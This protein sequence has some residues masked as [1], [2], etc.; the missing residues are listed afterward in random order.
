MPAITDDRVLVGPETRDDGGVYLLDENT[1]LV[2]TTDFF[3]PVVDDA[4]DFGRVAAANA[5]SDIY[6][7]GA[8]PL[9]ALNLVAYP[10]RTLPMELLGEIMLGGASVAAQA[11][12]PIL[13]GHSIDDPEPKY[14]LVVVGTVHPDA[15]LT[16]AGGKAGDVLILTKPLGSGVLTTAIKRQLASGAETQQ[17]TDLMATLNKAAGEVFA[18][19]HTHVNAL[20]DVTGFGLL[21]HLL[22]M[23]E[24]A[25]L[26]AEVRA[27]AVPVLDAAR[28][29]AEQGV[30]PGGSKANLKA[31]AERCD[32]DPNLGPLEAQLL[33]DAQTS[34][35]LLAAVP[36]A[37]ASA[38]PSDLE[39]AGASCA[40][41]IG[42]L[43]E[44]PARIRLRAPPGS[45]TPSST[46]ALLQSSVRCLWDCS[47]LNDPPAVCSERGVGAAEQ[48]TRPTYVSDDTIICTTPPRLAAGRSPP[49]R[50]AAARRRR[51][52]GARNPTP[53]GE[54]YVSEAWLTGRRK[55][56]LRPDQHTSGS[57]LHTIL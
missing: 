25:Q 34:G 8:K 40:V 32:L 21:G 13:G 28:R 39:A 24:G 3:T 55:R 15:V 50:Q 45:A 47:P 2:L 4:T 48:L 57:L 12:I 22:E 26:G 43:H 20:T 31:V 42:Q 29:Y 44:G 38:V 17:V 16:N 36:E 7:C 14:G 49:P 19:H 27:S 52:P 6:A 33:A 5:L 41:V 9:V 18:A 56:S 11:G 35:G 51:L 37:H 23:L 53:G 30:I 1:A 10:S 46:P 54:R